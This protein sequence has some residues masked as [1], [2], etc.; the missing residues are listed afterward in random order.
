MIYHHVAWLHIC[1]EVTE[2]NIDWMF[3][4]TMTNKYT[5]FKQIGQNVLTN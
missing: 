2:E 1:G 4:S 5:V 3:W